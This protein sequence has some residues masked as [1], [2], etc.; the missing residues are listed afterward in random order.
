MPCFKVV[1]SKQFPKDTVPVVWPLVQRS[2]EEKYF[3]AGTTEHHPELSSFSFTRHLT[4][5]LV[6]MMSITY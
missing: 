6:D 4:F 2:M 1:S 3:R 5:L